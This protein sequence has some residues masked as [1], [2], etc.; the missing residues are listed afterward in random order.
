MDRRSFLLN[1]STAFAG[2]FLLTPAKY[3]FARAGIA[4]P[5]QVHPRWLRRFDDQPLA[6]VLWRR[7]YRLIMTQ[8]F[9]GMNAP[10]WYDQPIHYTAHRFMSNPGIA[11]LEA[12]RYFV[13]EGSACHSGRNRALLWIDT[14]FN[15]ARHVRPAAALAVIEANS[16]GR[17]LWVVSNQPLVDQI[18][19]I[20]ASFRSSLHA[21]ILSRPPKRWDGGRLDGLNVLD[22][23]ILKRQP[24]AVK[25]G[26]PRKRLN[27]SAQAL[28]IEIKLPS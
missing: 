22:T 8:C 25:F 24:I 19:K 20:P 3:A 5:D 1:G 12:N 10:F 16:R 27:P 13:A 2:L 28:N 15:P 18:P 7:K 6:S 21:W 23:S 11:T 9:A 17:F 26:V 14:L 4:N